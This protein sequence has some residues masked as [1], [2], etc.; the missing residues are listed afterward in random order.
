VPIDVIS[1]RCRFDT[2]ILRQLRAFAASRRPD[3][4]WSNSVK[5]HFVVWWTGLKD[6]GSWVA[7]HHGYTSTDAKM[8]MYNQLDRWSLRAADLV[9]TPTGA[10]I[11]ELESRH[12]PKRRIHV[13]PMPVRAIPPVAQERRLALRR[14]LG[15]GPQALVLLC[16]ARLSREKGHADL[17]RAFAVMK[18]MAPELPLRLVLLGEGPERNRIARLC[19]ELQLT[20]QLVLAGH[21]TDV[22]SYYA[23]ANVLVLPS[24]SE[25]CPNVLL[26]AMAAG[27]PVVATAVGGIP[28][29]VENGQNALLVKARDVRGLAVATIR[30]LR[31]QRLLDRLTAGGRQIV[32]RNTPQRY[33][34]SLLTIFDQAR[35]HRNAIA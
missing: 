34:E 3:V 7:F 31:E 17:L 15:V 9:L 16:V 33:F 4:I 6:L 11:D 21:Q 1:E 22:N 2:G 26:E 30:V 8:L 19:R 14:E 18:E 24:L 27:V 13:Q 5:S 29:I 10:F 12:V 25:G 35:A 28:D 20:E 32:G 23:I